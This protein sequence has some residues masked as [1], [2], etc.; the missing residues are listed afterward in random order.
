MR[1]VCGRSYQNRLRDWAVFLALVIVLGTMLRAERERRALGA[2]RREAQ[3]VIS[4]ADS[5][6]RD[7]I[8]RG[9]APRSKTLP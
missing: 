3:A 8:A 6:M 2:D 1:C 4:Q 5:L 7:W 9:C